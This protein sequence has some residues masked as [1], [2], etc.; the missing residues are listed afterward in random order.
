[1]GISSFPP[2]VMDLL[3]HCGFAELSSTA[4][5]LI[6]VVV[7]AVDLLIWMIA[8]WEIL[9]LHGSMACKFFHFKNRS[10]RAVQALAEQQARDKEAQAA[11][12]ARQAERS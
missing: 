11:Y 4:W 5:T 12:K 8:L 6:A 1:M 9:Y 7:A 3:C 10:D 2:G